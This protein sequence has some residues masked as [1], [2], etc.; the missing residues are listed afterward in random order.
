MTLELFDV[1]FGRGDRSVLGPLTASF[2]GGELVGVVGPNGSGKSTLLRL[3]Y[4]YLRPSSGEV[5]LQ[6]EAISRIEPRRLARLLG[7]CPQEAEPTLDFSVDQALALGLGGDVDSSWRRAAEL[8]FLNLPELR[9]RQLS[10]LSGGEKQRI[11]VARALLPDPAWLVLDEPAN[12]LDL[13]TGWSLLEYL[14]K[15]RSGGVIVALHD[16]AFATRFCHRLVVLEGGLVRAFAPPEQALTET[17]LAGVFGLRG[18]VERGNGPPTL[19]V[20]GVASR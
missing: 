12:H 9:G 15:P 11:R 7:A 4:G 16:L 13:A 2:G 5:R 18:R 19:R 6:G 3:L 17:L 14:A 1:R 8:P 10:G 20:D